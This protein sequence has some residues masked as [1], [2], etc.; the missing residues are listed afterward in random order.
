MIRLGFGTIMEEVVE[1][2]RELTV[3]VQNDFGAFVDLVRLCATN[4][5]F[6]RCGMFVVAFGM[7]GGRVMPIVLCLVNFTR[8]LLSNGRCVGMGAELETEAVE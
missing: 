6:A 8:R 3:W 7:S 1:T 2:L 5:P 4:I